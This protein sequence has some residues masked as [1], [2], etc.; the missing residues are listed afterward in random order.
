MSMT[1]PSGHFNCDETGE[2]RFLVLLGMACHRAVFR[3]D[4][5]FGLSQ[6]VSLGNVVIVKRRGRMGVQSGLAGQHSVG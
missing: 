4:S 5:D 6:H 2:I 3:F 1:E